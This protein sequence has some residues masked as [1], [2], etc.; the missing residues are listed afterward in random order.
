MKKRSKYEKIQEEGTTV[1]N[2]HPFF[3]KCCDCGLVHKLCLFTERK[4]RGSPVGVAMKR[5]DRRTA[6]VRRQMSI[7]A[8]GLFEAGFRKP[9]TKAARLARKKKAD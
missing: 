9:I 6:A 3:I 7:A 2:G 8:E 1:K 5:D 4:Y